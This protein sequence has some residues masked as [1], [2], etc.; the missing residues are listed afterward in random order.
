[1]FLDFLGCILGFD[2]SSP[3]EDFAP[4]QSTH[5]GPSFESCGSC[6]SLGIWRIFIRFQSCVSPPIAAFSHLRIFDETFDRPLSL[7]SASRKVS[8][9]L[10]K[11]ERLLLVVLKLILFGYAAHAA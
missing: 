8:D 11:V 7:S 10:L 9:R 6:L 4:M 5:P 3:D 2:K 1:M